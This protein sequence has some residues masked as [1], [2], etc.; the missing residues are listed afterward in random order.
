[1]RTLTFD[2]IQ[3]VT[4]GGRAPGGC[5]SVGDTIPDLDDPGT[6]PG[7]CIVLDDFG[8]GMTAGPG[9]Q[10]CLGIPNQPT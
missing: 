1:M 6:P 2:E 9:S 5:Q 3:E 4:G 8:R 10:P 7:E